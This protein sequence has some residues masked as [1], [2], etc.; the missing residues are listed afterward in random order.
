[1]SSATKFV[2]YAGKVG[3]QSAEDSI[4]SPMLLED[5]QRNSLVYHTREDMSSAVVLLGVACSS[6]HRI[7]NILA[8]ILICNVLLAIGLWW[9]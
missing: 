1:V 3:N 2:R 6:L 9:Q 7:E 5:S 4:N 8:L